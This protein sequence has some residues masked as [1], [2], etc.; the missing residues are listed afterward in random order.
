MREPPP[1]ILGT[2]AARA[3]DTPLFLAEVFPPESDAGGADSDLWAGLIGLGKALRQGISLKDSKQDDDL[4]GL[5]SDSIAAS[6][7]L[8]LCEEEFG[9]TIPLC[10]LLDRPTF[11]AFRELVRCTDSPET[12]TT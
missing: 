10:Q 1:G 9:A 12:P 2:D 11:G 8:E 6:E 3:P 4:F 7:P 5:G